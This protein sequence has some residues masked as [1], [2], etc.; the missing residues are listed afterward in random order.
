MKTYRWI[1]VDKITYLLY[2]I[3]DL[4][5]T[6]QEV[7]KKLI[8][9]F[10][11]L[12]KLEDYFYQITYDTLDE[13]YATEYFNTHY[14]NLGGCSSLRKGNLYGRNYD[15]YYDKTP[16]FVVILPKIDGRHSSISICPAPKDM[17]NDFVSSR[18]Y[19]DLYKVV[20]FSVL[21]GINDSGLVCNINVVPTDDWG[22]TTGTTPAIELRKELNTFTLLRFVLDYFDNATDAVNYLRDYCSIKMIHTDTTH[23]EAH[24]MIADATKTYVVEFLNNQI[25]IIDLTDSRQYMTNFYLSGSAVNPITGLVERTSLTPHGSG[26]ERYELIENSYDDIADANG[27]MN[28]LH[29]ELKYTNAYDRTFDPY[30]YTE[31]VG[32]YQTFGDVTVT[33]PISAF[34]PVVDYAIG[35]YERRDRNTKTTWQTVHSV[36]YNMDKKS[37]VVIPQEGDVQYRFYL[38]S[39]HSSDSHNAQAYYYTD[40]EWAELDPILKEGEFGISSTSGFMKIGDGIHRWSEMDYAIFP[41]SLSQRQDNLLL[42]ENEQ[43]LFLSEGNMRKLIL[44]VIKQ[45]HGDEDIIEFITADAYSLLTDDNKIF[46]QKMQSI[47]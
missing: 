30:W 6:K 7:D 27:L 40:A 4:F 16:E 11:S 20:P 42:K 9:D 10:Y 45:Y 33:S 22:R 19:S 21:D 29:N 38:T 32:E 46:T 26:V 2:K 41:V 39:D 31:F 8:T 13:E 3:K 35:E 24:Y 18:I 23:I 34:E 14:F 17:D 47:H 12:V 5:Y 43:D 44:E 28:F 36:V 15:W 25:E 1:G 37:L